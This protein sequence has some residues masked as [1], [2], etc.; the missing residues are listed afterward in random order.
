[1]SDT[2]SI[3]L[4]RASWSVARQDSHGFSQQ[5][6]ATLFEMAP[7]TRS[8]FK[9]DLA[10]QGAKL[11]ATL[12]FVVDHL[13]DGDT[14]LPAARDLA[15]RHVAYGVG[16][17][18]YAPVGAALVATLQARVPEMGSQSAAAWASAY[19]DLSDHMVTSAHPNAS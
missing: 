17:Q 10:E 2:E 5:F 15:V 8:L 16:P 19:S 13:E 1:M 12:D 6:Y 4:I 14:L 18:D 11:M 9:D 3:R 7:A